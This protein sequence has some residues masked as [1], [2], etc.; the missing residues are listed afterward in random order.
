MV[1]NQPDN[2]RWTVKAFNLLMQLE[3]SKSGWYS[4]C[5]EGLKNGGHLRKL[6]ILST[7]CTTK[8]Y[9]RS[10]RLERSVVFNFSRTFQ[11]TKKE[12]NFEGG[13]N[14]VSVWSECVE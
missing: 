1:K 5:F 9:K 8:R 13:V 14:G 10:E 3:L 6:Q 7:V 12:T 11:L 4:V 2:L